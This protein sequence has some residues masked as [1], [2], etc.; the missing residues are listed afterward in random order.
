MVSSRLES[1][2]SDMPDLGQPFIVRS[3]LFKTAV[4]RLFSS[5]KPPVVVCQIP[6]FETVTQEEWVKSNYLM[7]ETYDVPKLWYFMQA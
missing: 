2:G 5:Y 4:F 7:N 6:F 1:F 3:V